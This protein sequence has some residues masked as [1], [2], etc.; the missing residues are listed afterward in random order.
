[1]KTRTLKITFESDWQIGS[2]AGIPGSVD[3]QVLRDE[4]GLPF[5]PAKTL[6]G[7]LRDAAEWIVDNGGGKPEELVELF[8]TQSEA[9]GD[10]GGVTAQK[11]GLSVRPARFSKGL[12]TVLCGNP[13]LRD[14]LFLV[15]PH[16]KISAATGRAEENHLF[17]LE[18]VRAGV[19]LYAELTLEEGVSNEARTLLEK[20]VKAVRHMGG[21][22][23]RGAGKCKLQ[24]QAKWADA[25]GGTAPENKKLCTAEWQT[26]PVTLTAEEPLQIG[27][28]VLGNTVKTRDYIPGYLLLPHV[29]KAL[30]G[31]VGKWLASGELQVSDLTPSVDGKPGLPMPMCLFKRKEAE[32]ETVY[33]RATAKPTDNTQLRGMRSGYVA[34]NEQALLWVDTGKAKTLRMHNTVEDASQ[35]PTETVG[36]VFSYEVMRRGLEY[37][38]EIRCTKEVA[39]RLKTAAV[40]GPVR[41]G[42]SKKDDYGKATLTLG[43]ADPLEA[44]S[45]ELKTGETLLV[46][47]ESDVLLRDPRTLAYSA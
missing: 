39:E 17:S 35:R 41:L 12:R 5:V 43:T 9:H 19:P 23:R 38:G 40:A 28:E 3:R 2:G 16:V 1:M 46:Y 26:L 20:A 22:R 29:A 31:D 24:L 30:G 4:D 8:G 34:T 44:A 33:N 7:I 13:E 21:K 45:P 10:N 14:A 18:Q 47:L 32:T 15:E 42:R 27:L 6:T 25:Q 37:R 11:A 36:G